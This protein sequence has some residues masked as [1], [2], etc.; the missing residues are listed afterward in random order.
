MNEASDKSLSE[1]QR[2]A[3]CAFVY[4]C[5]EK[6]KSYLSGGLDEERDDEHGTWNVLLDHVEYVKSYAPHIHHMVFD[7]EC[8]PESYYK[9]LG[10]ED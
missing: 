5:A 7:L 9:Q 1:A 2:L 10:A 3:T 6:L 4:D 8:R